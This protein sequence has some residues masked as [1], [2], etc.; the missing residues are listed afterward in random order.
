MLRVRSEYNYI[1]QLHLIII[2]TD[3]IFSIYL[4]RLFVN[5]DYVFVRR[6]LVDEEANVLYIMSKSTEHTKYPKY[7]EK[8]RIEDYWSIM[9]IRPYTDIKKPGIEFSLTYFDNPGVNVP[10]SITNWVAMRAMPDF[11]ER[12]RKATLEYRQYCVRE[13][14]SEACLKIAAEEKA[15]AEKREREKL[16]YCTFERTGHAAINIKENIQTIVESQQYHLE[17]TDDSKKIEAMADIVTPPTS[18]M[19]GSKSFW[20]YFHPLYYFH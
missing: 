11:L 19:S 13:G 6:Y 17:L 2:L 3:I 16:D 7:P 20:R 4:Q 18:A 15:A 8:Y 5:R 9:V 14:I 12:L 1:L 10:S